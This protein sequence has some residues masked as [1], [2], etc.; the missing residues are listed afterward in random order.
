MSNVELEFSS[1]AFRQGYIKLSVRQDVVEHIAPMMPAPF[2][3]RAAN[4]LMMNKA[5]DL[6]PERENNRENPIAGNQ[7]DEK[8][9]VHYLHYPR[10]RRSL[11]WSRG[12]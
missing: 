4:D 6:I 12:F 2:V 9:G 1:I 11:S 5:I 7:G 8:A 10:A 3:V